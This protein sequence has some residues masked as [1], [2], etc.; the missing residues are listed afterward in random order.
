MIRYIPTPT[1]NFTECHVSKSDI[2]KMKRCWD[3]FGNF[4]DKNNFQLAAGLYNGTWISGGSNERRSHARRYPYR[5]ALHAEQIALMSARSDYEGANLYVCRVSENDG[6][7][8]LSKPCFWCMHNL[9]D[10]GISKVFYTEDDSSI[11]GFKV[12]T[13]KIAPKNSVDINYQMIA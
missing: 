4:D 7:F 12:S 11:T 10:V 8:K 1:Y 13:V 5:E 3:L 9:I 2:I 6:L